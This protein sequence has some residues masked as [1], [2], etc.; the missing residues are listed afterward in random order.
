M[1]KT[2]KILIAIFV[3][4]FPFVMKG[5]GVISSEEKRQ[6]E[7]QF[8]S[9]K[10]FY[11]DDDGAVV[12]YT[13]PVDSALIEENKPTP[14]VKVKVSVD[15]DGNYVVS[16]NEDEVDETALTSKPKTEI[17]TTINKETPKNVSPVKKDSPSASSTVADILPID[18]TTVVRAKKGAA[19][20]E[21]IYP[22]LEA[23]IMAVEEKMEELK[24]Q[25]SQ[26][27]KGSKGSSSLSS[28][29]SRGSVDGSLRSGSSKLNINETTEA[30]ANEEE[31][32]YG[33]EPTYYING[34][35]ADKS[36]VRKLKQR[37]IVKKEMRR[38][39]KNPNGEIWI[40]LR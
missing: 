8:K 37:D 11:I 27:G 7:E 5:Q 17:Q 12:Y 35:V 25:Y 30:S 23:A 13:E 3:I 34:E 4:C 32:D 24:K 2:S 31:H 39:T 19:K 6:L 22:T 21:S 36:E 16:S 14:R 38:S 15:N 33:D 40:E 29:L 20:S 9:L 28:K 1:N 10:T 18:T 26:G